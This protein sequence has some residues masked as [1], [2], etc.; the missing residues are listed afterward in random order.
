[1][2]PLFSNLPDFS[3]RERENYTN[4]LRIFF[5]SEFYVEIKFHFKE[6]LSHQT[7]IFELLNI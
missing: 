4:E 6:L 5:T 2:Q 3:V 1:M 7:F